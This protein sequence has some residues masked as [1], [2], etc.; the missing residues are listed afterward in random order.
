MV[1]DVLR[2]GSASEIVLQ[3]NT[4]RLMDIA[5]EQDFFF[6]LIGSISLQV[7]ETSSG[8]ICPRF[9]LLRSM[10]VR[11]ANNSTLDTVRVRVRKNEASFKSVTI[12]AGFNGITVNVVTD[13][14]SVAE[15][16]VLNGQWHFDDPAE[17]NTLS[18]RGFTVVLS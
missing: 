16:D 8:T 17:P 9:V 1:F 15:N 4:L 3:S 2:R 11:T 10:R 14:S 6:N 13:G 7:T 5:G 18:F 12:P